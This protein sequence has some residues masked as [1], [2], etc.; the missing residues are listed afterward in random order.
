MTSEAGSVS[1]NVAFRLL[2]GLC[3]AACWAACGPAML[4]SSVASSFPNQKNVQVTCD[5]AP[6]DISS[7]GKTMSKRYADGWRVAASG[8]YGDTT[9]MCFEKP[10]GEGSE[11]SVPNAA[12]PL[13]I[14]LE[15]SGREA[16]DEKRAKCQEVLVKFKLPIDP[17][18]AI[19]GELVLDNTGNRLRITS[20]KQGVLFDEGRPG[21]STEELCVDA[22]RQL[23]K[24]LRQE[25]G[26]AG[27]EQDFAEPQ[28]D[29][30]AYKSACA[31]LA[32]CQVDV[33]NDPC[34]AMNRGHA[35]ACVKCLNDNR[36]NCSAVDEIC[37]RACKARE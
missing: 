3:A 20:V 11:S 14:F 25:G 10:A 13:A 2:L 22:A 36:K 23:R 19:Q 28:Y 29:P 27:S 12:A 30:G 16:N 15:I 33:G 9:F 18:A 17:R 34:L 26:T 5:M 1:R 7:F 21:S 32:N 37:R 24:A 35:E 8:F 6:R 31:V 4:V